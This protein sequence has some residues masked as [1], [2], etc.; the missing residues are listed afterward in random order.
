M[1]ALQ[2]QQIAQVVAQTG[3]KL[4]Q[5]GLSVW[6]LSQTGRSQLAGKREL[7]RLAAGQSE[8]TSQQVGDRQLILLVLG[9]VKTEEVVELWLEEGL[10]VQSGG[11]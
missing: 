2:A 7:A 11:G 4:S 6:E 3:L 1:E 5:T 8:L 10:G 9:M